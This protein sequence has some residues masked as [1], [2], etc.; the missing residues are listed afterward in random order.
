MSS[1]VRVRVR[2][3]VVLSSMVVVR[4]RVAVRKAEDMDGIL[5]CNTAQMSRRQQHRSPVESHLLGLS[6]GDRL[7]RHMF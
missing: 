5:T 4:V 3:R 6:S 1:Q 2:V 7:H